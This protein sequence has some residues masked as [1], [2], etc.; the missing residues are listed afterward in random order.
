MVLGAI[1][2][3]LIFI[4]AYHF[5]V[6]PGSAAIQDFFNRHESDQHSE[7]WKVAQDS[8]MADWTVESLC[9]FNE[10]D[11]PANWM[12]DP[13]M[14]AT[15]FS[16]GSRGLGQAQ[17]D[18]TQGLASN[19]SELSDLFGLING[20]QV[21]ATTG[22]LAGF[23]S[24]ARQ[25]DLQ[26]LNGGIAAFNEVN[27]QQTSLFAANGMIGLYLSTLSG[28]NSLSARESLLPALSAQMNALYATELPAQVLAA[29]N[30]QAITSCN[31]HP[32]RIKIG[33]TQRAQQV[34]DVAT[35]DSAVMPADDLQ[36][37]GITLVCGPGGRGVFGSAMSVLSAYVLAVL[38]IAVIFG[39]GWYLVHR[40]YN[41]GPYPKKHKQYRVYL[42]L[43]ASMVVVG[44]FMFALKGI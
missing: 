1:I 10:D 6:L 16:C 20:M 32:N 2:L 37:S 26:S 24:T 43:A 8:F 34:K 13:G 25:D 33:S 40:A 14:T 39:V 5:N 30:I 28:G 31:N 3:T 9:G 38:A 36:V 17:S 12:Q 4:P 42:P 35:G 21:E 29:E 41:I 11:M 44:L 15:V 7:T 19:P 27:A 23:E 18:I 22:G